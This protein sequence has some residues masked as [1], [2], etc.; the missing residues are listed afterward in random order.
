MHFNHA[1]YIWLGVSLTGVFVISF[2][3]VSLKI[4]TQSSLSKKKKYK[5]VIKYV[6]LYVID[7]YLMSARRECVLF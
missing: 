4:I 2:K 3:N 7:R 5:N 1:Y 6:T